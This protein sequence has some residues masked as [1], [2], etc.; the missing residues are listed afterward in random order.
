[1]TTP[2]SLRV[3]PA[4]R[5]PRP[6]ML[7]WDTPKVSGAAEQSQRLAEVFWLTKPQPPHSGVGSAAYWPPAP[8]LGFLAAHGAGSFPVGLTAWTGVPT[9]RLRVLSRRGRHTFH[10]NVYLRAAQRPSAASQPER[11]KPGRQPRDERLAHRLT[12]RSSQHPRLV[13]LW[14]GVCNPMV[15]TTELRSRRGEHAD[16]ADRGGAEPCGTTAWSR[17]TCTTG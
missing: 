3:Q 4:L 7:F 2:L 13:L 17:Q 15:Q 9:G 16:R 10:T 14:P 12:W 11:P 1:M 8:N 5:V 6:R